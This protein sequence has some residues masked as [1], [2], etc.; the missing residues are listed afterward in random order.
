[1]CQVSANSSERMKC[2]WDPQKTSADQRRRQKLQQLQRCFCFSLCVTG[3]CFKRLPL[4]LRQMQKFV[5]AEKKISY[6]TFLNPFK[7]KLC[8]HRSDCYTSPVKM[9]VDERWEISS[10][11]APSA[12]TTRRQAFSDAHR[13]KFVVEKRRRRRKEQ[14]R[15]KRRN[16][17]QWRDSF[18]ARF[19]LQQRWRFQFGP[20]VQPI[21]RSFQHKKE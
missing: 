5:R 19:A 7:K 9:H 12:T 20:P 4:L 17:R 16:H 18:P 15:R 11:S 3:A 21:V 13:A 8:V 6:R 10:F 1:M 14:Q 2:I